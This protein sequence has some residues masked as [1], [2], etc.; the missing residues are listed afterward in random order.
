[1][2]VSEVEPL[3]SKGMPHANAEL[4]FPFHEQLAMKR[5]QRQRDGMTE[6]R[7]DGRTEEHAAP[8]HD[9]EEAAPML[10]ALL[11][12]LSLTHAKLRDSNSNVKLRRRQTK[13][14]LYG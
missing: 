9:K 5:Q 6:R 2:R 7:K 1:M 8:R 3:Q 10:P 4:L 12:N 11:A 13:A 14:A